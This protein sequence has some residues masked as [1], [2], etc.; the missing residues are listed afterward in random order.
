MVCHPRKKEVHMHDTTQAVNCLSS[1]FLNLLKTEFLA[2]SEFEDEAKRTEKSLTKNYRIPPHT[3][4]SGYEYPHNA[5][6]SHMRTNIKYNA[7]L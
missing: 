2:L 1:V 5:T 3:V 4:G 6:V 7:G